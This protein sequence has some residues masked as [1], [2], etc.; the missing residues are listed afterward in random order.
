M[1]TE[2]TLV[3]GQLG[4]FARTFVRDTPA[5]V[6]RAVADA[7]FD[8]VQLN[9]NS[10]G[11]PTI[12]EC[13]VL[14]GIDF[15]A[16]RDA[17]SQQGIG[18]WGVSVTYN[19]IHPDAGVR[20]RLTED[21][22]ALI[23][24]VPELGAGFATLCTGTRDPDNMWRAHPANGDTSAFRDLRET[25]DRLL[26]AATVAGV[27][28]GVEPE[29][30]NVISNARTAAALLDDLGPDTE[31]VG[32]VLDPANLV[33]ATT[34]VAQRAIL[35]EAFEMLAGSVVCLHAKD[36]ALTGFAAAGT[37]LLDYELIFE[38]RSELPRPVPVVVQ[39]VAEGDARR[40]RDM[41]IDQFSR[42]PIR[43]DAA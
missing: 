35:S 26:E 15:A 7:G 39:D 36:V 33:D 6:A 13:D 2:S 22:C 25:I 21:A 32:I 14:A 24:R 5:A 10:F 12:P 19:T 11:L 18:I 37:G 17:F 28:L 42:H 38:L 8:L 9:L 27:R 31:H 41:L 1:E 29:P 20:R 16:V 3:A 34:A 40:V 30:A 43:R 4:I 23:A